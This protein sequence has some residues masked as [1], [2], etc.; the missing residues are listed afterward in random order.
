MMWGP[1]FKIEL[2]NSASTFQSKTLGQVNIDIPHQ[3]EIQQFA[4]RCQSL[5]IQFKPR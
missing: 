2:E 1:T 4:T 3:V 5:R